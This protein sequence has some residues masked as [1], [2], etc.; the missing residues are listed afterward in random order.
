[1][2]TTVL[3]ENQTRLTKQKKREN[4]V[5]VDHTLP[6]IDPEKGWESWDKTIS[7]MFCEAEN[8]QVLCKACHILKTKEE[9]NGR[10]KS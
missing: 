7:R 1:M 2:P 10:T 8:L 3:S 4:N 9:R 6:V 5:F